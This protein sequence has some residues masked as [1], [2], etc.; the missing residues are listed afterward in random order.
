MANNEVKLKLSVDGARAVLSDFDRVRSGMSGVSDAAATA[1]GAMRALG[2]AFSVGAAV[3]WGKAMI[4]AADSM[5]DMSQRVGIAVRDLAKYELAASQSGTTMET[6]AKGIKGLATNLVEHGTALKK[7]GIDTSNADKAMQQLANVFASM[8]DGVEKTN[9]AVKLFG[10][11]GMDMIPMLNLGA[12]GLETAAEK[13]AAYAT[14]MATMAPL[15]DAFNDNLSVMSLNS[16]TLSMTMFNEVLP[17]LVKVTDA[18]TKTNDQGNSLASIF[19][20]GLRIAFETV[21]LIAS[22]V[23]Y[24]FASVGREIGGIAAQVVAA[25]TGNWSGF[26][27]I[28]DAM[29]EDAKNARIEL[30]RF[31]ENLVNRAEKAQT[32]YNKRQGFGE[33]SKSTASGSAILGALGADKS[34]AD[35]VKAANA[36]LKEQIEL[37]KWNTK[38]VDELFDAQEKTRLQTED[39][40]K[41]ARTTLE[42]IEFETRLLEMNTEQRAQATLERELER[43]GIVK[44]TLAYDAYIVKLREAVTIKTGKEAGIKAADDMREAQKKAAEESSKY[45]ED[46]LMRAFESGK[47]FFQSL[48]DTIKNTLKTQ[49]LKVMVSATGMTGM[50]AAGAS[51]LGGSGSGNLLG[52]ASSL[53]NIYNTISAGFAGLGDSVA[54]AAQDM[55]AWLVN[56]TSGVLNEAG[57]SLMQGAGTFGT[58]AGYAAGA[59]AGLAIGN[60]ISG[61]YGSSN[62][63]TAGTIIGSVVGGPIGGAIGGAIGGIINRAFGMGDTEVRATGTQGTFSGDSFTG[64]NYATMH[65]DG[66]WFRSDR[67]WTNT[68]AIDPATVSAWST[69]F[70]GVKGSV[71]GMAASL[72]LATDKI[73]AYSKA[74][75][76]AAGTTAEQIT[77]LFTGMA[78]DMALAAAPSLAQFAKTGEVAST[79][80]ARLSGSLQT[81]NM[82]LGTLDHT[83]LAVSLSGGDAASK[84]ADAFGGL[85]AMAT[86][87]KAYYDLFWTDAERLSDTAINVAKG[88]AL[89][90]Q[91]MP[92]TKDAFREV[93][94]A[95]DLTTDAG[96]NTYAVMLALA[97]E[98]AQVA[99]AADTARQATQ[100]MSDAMGKT[101]AGAFAELRDLVEAA[102]GDLVDAFNSAASALADTATRFASIQDIFKGFAQSLAGATGAGQSLAYLRG[103]FTRLSDLARLGDA[104]AASS[105]VGVGDQLAAKIIATSGSR[106][107][108]DLQLARLAAQANATASIA[109]QQKT[110]AQQQLDTLKEVVGKLVDV[111]GKTLSVEEAM[112]TLRVL[113]SVENTSIAGAI[114]GGFGNLLASGGLT[115][116]GVAKSTAAIAKGNELAASIL[117]GINT[118]AGIQQAQE[119]ERLAIAKAAEDE[120]IRQAKISELNQTGLSAAQAY[121]SVS[122]SQQ[123]AVGGVKAS[124]SDIW[125]LASAYGL[126][127][128]AQV[129]QT[130]NTAQFGVDEAGKFAATYNQISGDPGNF[131]AFKSAFYA[132]GGV[133]D[134]T[135]GQASILAALAGQVTTASAELER[136][137]ELVRAL[138]GTPAF[139]SG[140]SFTGGLRIV[141][142][143]GPELE[144]TGPSR[145]FNADQ[146]RSLLQSGGGSEVVAELRALRQ[147]NEDMRSELR[148]IASASVKTAKIL[149]R[150][151]QDGESITTTVLA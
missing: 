93:V 102:E 33:Q 124:I 66:G 82:W 75:D 3:A 4:N 101:V 72:G 123:A 60:A 51:D 81:V 103:E 149:G 95:L 129:G 137:R 130:G 41:T 62:T 69:A 47:G 79:T 22:D 120:R 89:V 138:G 117:S 119:A 86:A 43:E 48:W 109:E 100:D 28:S 128:Q 40:I 49:V 112:N 57:A 24:M 77:A 122:S 71:A 134:R 144:A 136:Q 2:A 7:A 32:S 84:L 16:K 44:G 141:G 13:T 98:F 73:S 63:V 108:A 150:V 107:Q 127:L 105:A 148:A 21:A 59:A 35:A 143:H 131:A 15:A 65:Q 36:L 9:L 110:I 27:A 145:I 116:D 147:S 146:T 1:S 45:W 52:V 85:D 70:A 90:G 29:K 25:A 34:A 80:L 94:T 19:G 114:A 20:K 74:V 6:L 135:Y 12:E 126:T 17:S 151:T 39:K 104:S 30:D 83:L 18:M 37:A 10:K 118:M 111:E 68:S 106:T 5:N 142:E 113:Q 53:G 76:I 31:Q 46:A 99:D 55:G 133:Y 61:Q 125:S 64:S 139:A 121:Q 78:D 140:G 11:A 56:N 97:P 14:Q 96:R 92:A 132:A 23:V 26:S 115:L 88:L 91:A 8:P 67:D 50:S 54:F 38:A 42:Q 87:S 58:V